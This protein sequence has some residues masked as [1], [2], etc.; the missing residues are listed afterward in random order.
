MKIGI[1][2]WGSDGD[3]HPFIALAAGLAAA[4][5]HVTLAITSAERKSYA[6]F[7]ERLDFQ[8][9]QVSFIGKDDDELISLAT[10][11]HQ[12]ANPLKQLDVIIKEMFEPGVAAMFAAARALSAEN[13]LLIGHF[14]AHP[15]ATAAELAGKPYLTVTLNQ[16]AIPTDFAP[17]IGVPYLGRLLNHLIWNIGIKILNRHILP[18]INRLRIKE[19]LTPAASFRQIWESP[20]ANLIAVSPAFCPP[21]PDWGA[22]QV[23]CGFFNLPEEARP[24][25]MPDDLRQFLKAGPPPVYITF[26][27][28]LAVLKDKKQLTQT[29]RMLVDSARQAGC[30]AIIQSR[31]PEIDE[32][33]EDDT[34]Y[35]ISAAPHPKIFPLC[36]AVVH[37]GGAGTTQTATLCGCPSVVVAHIVDQYLWGQELTR[38]RIAPN[39]LDRRRV[40]P[41]QLGR[42]IRQVLDSPDMAENAGKLGEQ[43]HAERGVKAAVAAISTVLNR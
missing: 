2:T 20:L 43:L 5:H 14:L 11:M 29:T 39:L 17:P 22:N 32:I 16:S 18:P 42:A 1:Q 41:E 7:A 15:L 8:L 9:I 33:P 19:G 28:M 38:L 13:D 35:R 26:G 10:A 6:H 3:I 23:I 27:S 37:H 24:W 31:W 25:D 30:R 4:G 36:A 40:T 12:A 21:R 34:I